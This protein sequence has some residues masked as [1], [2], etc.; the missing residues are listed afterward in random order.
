M[1]ASKPVELGELLKF[2]SAISQAAPFL[3]ILT[4]TGQVSHK[5]FP[6]M[7]VSRAARCGWVRVR[8]WEAC[9]TYSTPA[10]SDAGN[11]TG[12][13][14]RCIRMV[15]LL[16]I[17]PVVSSHALTPHSH[18]LHAAAVGV[19]GG[20]GAKSQPRRPTE[21]HLNY[22]QKY[23]GFG[24]KEKVFAQSH[25]HVGSIAIV[26]S[27]AERESVWVGVRLATA[28]VTLVETYHITLIHTASVTTTTTFR[29]IPTRIASYSSTQSAALMCSRQSQA[30]SIGHSLHP[31]FTRTQSQLTGRDK[32]RFE[33]LAQLG[34]DIFGDKFY[35]AAMTGSEIV[36]HH[37]L[38]PWPCVASC[39]VVFQS[40]LIKYA[41]NGAH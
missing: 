8:S 5:S 16:S 12:F 7:L 36:L 35:T 29:Q 38:T 13:V 11:G 6:T 20:G 15:P 24:E 3:S 2:E 25:C 32:W 21:G 10:G 27:T 41:G 28:I 17:F 19:G 40:C 23:F 26:L 18:T 34:R 37:P 1:G 30:I 4:K 33:K 39:C 14:F 9:R 31:C 22:K